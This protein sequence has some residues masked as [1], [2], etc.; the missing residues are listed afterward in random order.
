[1]KKGK[2]FTP[3][4]IISK[5]DVFKDLDMGS[6]LKSNH[7]SS[8]LVRGF[9]LIELLV[10]I[11][12]IGILAVLIFLALERSREAARDSQRKAFSRDI[13][14]AEAI[15][16]DTHKSY[17]GNL[18]GS[19]SL[20]NDTL[21]DVDKVPK[22]CPQEGLF[23]DECDESDWNTALTGGGRSFEVSALMERGGGTFYCDQN[24]CGER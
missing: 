8:K 5:A 6:K 4:P 18:T 9:T 19:N 10:V 13:A 20:V 16:Y 14:T 2:G 24:G 7:G 23:G 22:V 1:M 12:I 3:T 15:Y 21:I 11:A 17:T